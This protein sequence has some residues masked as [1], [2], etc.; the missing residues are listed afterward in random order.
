MPPMNYTEL[1]W[2]EAILLGSALDN[3]LV[4]AVADTSRSASEVADA[5]GFDRRAV[6]V[7][8]SAL[9]GIGLLEESERGFLLGEEHREPLLERDHADY[10]GAAVVH[11][12]GLIS[13]WSRMPEVLQS[14]DPVED[15]TSPD[16]SGTPTFIGAMRSGARAGTVAVAEAV[17]PLLPEKATILD[18]GGG[19]GT[20][21]EAFAGGGARVTVFDRP[22]VIELMKEPLA[23]AG[24]ATES[25]DMN[26]ALPAGPFDAIYFGNTSH[27]YG[28]D[29]NRRLFGMMRA[30]LYPGGLLAVRDFVRGM[31]GDAALFAVNMLVTTARGDTYTAKDYEEWLLG[32]GFKGVEFAP[33]PGRSTHL[34]LARN[35]G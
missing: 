20:N 3:G 8:L 35:P 12:F 7:V 34:I 32:A 11:R 10:V 29:E 22:E 28:P 18:V 13:S 30:S 14:G 25:G 21:A 9:A 2:R 26:E 33:V 5:L 24:I 4:G 31:S 27:M 17:L 6:Y 23:A 16:F 1:D 19:P 15:R